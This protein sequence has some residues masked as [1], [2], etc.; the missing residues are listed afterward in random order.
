MQEF[1]DE[2]ANIK[3][4]LEDLLDDTT[5]EDLKEE[6]NELIS[7]LEEDYG[8]RKQNFIERINELE[9]EEEDS[10]VKEYYSMRL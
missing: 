1:V 7:S 2:Y 4:K 5:N 9:N 8:E 3:E 10:L 6:L